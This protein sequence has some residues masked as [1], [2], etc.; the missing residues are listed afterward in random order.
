MAKNWFKRLI[1]KLLRENKWLELCFISLNSVLFYGHP[2]NIISFRR[3][4]SEVHRP[5]LKFGHCGHV[6]CGHCL[7]S[8]SNEPCLYDDVSTFFC[9]KVNYAQ[10]WTFAQIMSWFTIKLPLTENL[11]AAYSIV[12]EIV[13]LDWKS[14]VWEIFM[15]FEVI[16]I[17]HRNHGYSTPKS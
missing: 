14:P 11:N 3:R 15:C 16:W 13:H 4:L 17:V 9:S 12:H 10:I 5:L 1:L 2:C 7:T 8:V 6:V